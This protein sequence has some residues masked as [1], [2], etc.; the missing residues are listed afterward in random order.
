MNK[1]LL[2][3]NIWN[4]ILAKDKKYFRSSTNSSKSKTPGTLQQPEVL[5]DKC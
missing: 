4:E 3:F 1:L 2:L 5:I